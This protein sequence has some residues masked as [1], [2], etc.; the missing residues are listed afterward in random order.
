MLVPLPAS[1]RAADSDADEL[2]LWAGQ[3]IGIYMLYEIRLLGPTGMVAE[4]F[5]FGTPGKVSIT[6]QQGQNCL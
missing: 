5:Q 1:L 6:T 3:R 2:E 4:L